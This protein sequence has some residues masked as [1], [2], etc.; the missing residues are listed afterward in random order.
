MPD[1][2]T[3]SADSRRAC[4]QL[5]GGGSSA[6]G[7]KRTEGTFLSAPPCLTELANRCSV[8]PGAMRARGVVC[9]SKAT[10]RV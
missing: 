7:P 3:T 6:P 4:L 8:L 9:E 1:A 10:R 5:S 2:D